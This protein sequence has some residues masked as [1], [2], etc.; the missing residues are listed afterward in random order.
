MLI[1]YPSKV[2]SFVFED[3]VSFYIFTL[4]FS[5]SSYHIWH[6]QLELLMGFKL[7]TC[8]IGPVPVCVEMLQVVHPAQSRIR[9]GQFYILLAQYEL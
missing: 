7:C 5:G 6:V 2:C 9:K 3:P 1:N 8:F 4:E